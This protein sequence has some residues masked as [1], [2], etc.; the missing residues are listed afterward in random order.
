[1]SKTFEEFQ[2]KRQ[3]W[4]ECLNGE[5]PHS[6]VNQIHRLLEDAGIWFLIW[7]ARRYAGRSS[8]GDLELN[9]AAHRLIDRCCFQ[10]QLLAVRRLV[11]GDRSVYS[12]VSLLDDMIANIPLFA[13]EHL[14]AAANLPYDYQR[15]EREEREHT[16]KQHAVSAPGEVLCGPPLH[17]PEGM[18]S[19]RWHRRIDE[20]CGVSEKARKPHDTV[21]QKVFE[22]LKGKLRAASDKIKQGVNKFLAHAATPAS[23]ATVEAELKTDWNELRKAHK[24]VCHVTNFLLRHFF[25]THYT[26]SM[27]RPIRATLKYMDR[28]FVPTDKIDELFKAWDQEYRAETENWWREEAGAPE[29]E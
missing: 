29:K 24:V 27:L 14:L 18:I 26:F 22:D 21:P 23:R 16:I 11:D 19:E 12:L 25:G 1:M 8:D 20:W 4:L 7:R 17:G 6:I 13:R 3:Q 2:Q 10:S 5:D 9:T 15:I 28:S